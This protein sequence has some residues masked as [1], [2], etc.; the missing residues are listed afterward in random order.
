MRID[1]SRRFI[2][3]ETENIKRK[4]QK[5]NM[6]LKLKNLS[7]KVCLPQNRW[8][9]IHFD[10]KKEICKEIKNR[11]LSDSLDVYSV[12][13]TFTRRPRYWTDGDIHLFKVHM[14][15]L[16]KLDAEEIK[17]RINQAKRYFNH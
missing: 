16:N 1:N 5:K 9:H 15:N 3:E 2:W 14:W 11:G 7:I 10:E 17:S 4:K 12:E 6:L 13:N 8:Q